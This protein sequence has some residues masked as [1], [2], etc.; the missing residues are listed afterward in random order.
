MK[1]FTFDRQLAFFIIKIKQ[2]GSEVIHIFIDNLISYHILNI[3]LNKPSH[4][5]C[6]VL[7]RKGLIR[8]KITELGLDVHVQVDG[9]IND[10]TASIVTEAGADVLVSGSYLFRENNMKKAAEKLRKGRIC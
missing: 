9:G 10:A 3:T 8:N 5:T 2:D 7:L 4:I 6:A 1:L